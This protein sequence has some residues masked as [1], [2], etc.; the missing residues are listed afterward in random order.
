MRAVD[1]VWVGQAHSLWLML[2]AQLLIDSGR[3]AD[4]KFAAYVQADAK[5]FADN[6]RKMQPDAILVSEGERVALMQRE[7]AIAEAMKGYAPAASV[8]DV[9]VWVPKT[10]Q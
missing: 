10:Q 5:M 7:P 8:E 1:G 2:C 4:P 6:V 3:G 9:A